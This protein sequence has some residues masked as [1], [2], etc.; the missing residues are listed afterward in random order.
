MMDRPVRKVMRRV[1]SKQAL[2]AVGD[3]VH[4]P[5]LQQDRAKVDAHNCT[6]IVVSINNHFG[7]C[8]LVVKDGILQTW[9]VFHKI[10][11]LP[12]LGTDRYLNDLEDALKKWKTINLSP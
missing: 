6:V 7:V 5:L 9:Y 3:V 10:R 8:Q 4:I 11:H 1:K 2:I 12:D